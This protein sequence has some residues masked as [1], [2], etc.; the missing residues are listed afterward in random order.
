[1]SRFELIANG[2]HT[3]ISGSINRI[4]NFGYGEDIEKSISVKTNTI[5]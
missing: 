4:N 1:M 2:I 5:K 3:A